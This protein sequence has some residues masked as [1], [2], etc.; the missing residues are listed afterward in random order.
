M[1]IQV[2][3]GEG[4]IA[5]EQIQLVD[6]ETTIGFN[7]S[8]GNPDNS[9]FSAQ[10]AAQAG[11]YTSINLINTSG[12]TRN[13]QLTAV[14]AD[15]T[16]LAGPVQ[17][18]LQAGEQSVRDAADVF[19]N[20][21]FVGSLKVDSDGFGVLG[22]VIFGDRL[23]FEY[24]ASLP[25][26]NQSFTEAV[27]SQVANVPGFF[28]GLAFYVPGND[29]AEMQI[30]VV[31]ADGT[32]VGEETRDLAAGERLAQLVN[33][34]VPDSTGQAGGYVL[35]RSNVPVISQLLFGAIQPGGKITLFSAVPPTVISEELAQ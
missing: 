5:F 24:A 17:L 29:D 16:T 3:T 2:T 21:D 8:F 26:Q 35:I 30:Q 14:A 25:L 9:S 23:S 6:Q 18:V 33:Q 7:A 20:A 27:F 4:A 19:S 28:T 22:D 31:A 11:L 10:L 32:V 34:L 12:L 1:T 15:G 13:V